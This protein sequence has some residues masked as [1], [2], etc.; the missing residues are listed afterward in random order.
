MHSL[1]RCLN[2][3]SW[4]NSLLPW[5]RT[6]TFFDVVREDSPLGRILKNCP[7]CLF[8]TLA[9]GDRARTNFVLGAED[10]FKMRVLLLKNV[11]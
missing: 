2:L 1:I 11:A 7:S 9:N 10:V 4:H 8:S 5:Y 6:E 3:V